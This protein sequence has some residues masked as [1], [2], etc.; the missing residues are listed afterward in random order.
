V[1]QLALKRSKKNK[2]YVAKQKI[3]LGYAHMMLEIFVVKVNI[4]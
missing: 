2:E 1:I 3:N 4:K